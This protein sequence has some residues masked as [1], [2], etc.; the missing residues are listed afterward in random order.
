MLLAG[1]RSQAEVDNVVFGWE[2]ES[3]L[4]ERKF[5]MSMYYCEQ[6]FQYGEIVTMSVWEKSK[7]SLPARC[8]MEHLVIAFPSIGILTESPVIDSMI[9]ITW[10]LSSI[11]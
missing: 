9:N 2:N 5:N 3:A 1:L 10:N 4:S 8:S 11:F 7:A 6:I